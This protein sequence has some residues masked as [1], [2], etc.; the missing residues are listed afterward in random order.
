M[1]MRTPG[2]RFARRKLNQLFP[3]WGRTPPPIRAHFGNRLWL[4]ELEK[5]CVPTL[6]AY[7]GVPVTG[8]IVDYPGGFTGTTSDGLD[9]PTDYENYENV[10]ATINWGDGTGT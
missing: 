8:S 7:A 6:Y 2:W 10:S 5:R 3:F 1:F 9:P 4:E